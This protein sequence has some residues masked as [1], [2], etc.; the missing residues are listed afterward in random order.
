MVQFVHPGA[1]DITL[2]GVLAA[3]ADPVRLAIV[4]ALMQRGDCASCTGLTPSGQ[5][6]KSTLSRHF[7]ILRE[8]GL[9]HTAKKGVENSNGLRRA[10]IEAKFPGLL[11]LV[12][13]L[14]EPK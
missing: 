3:L 6:A 14:A 5:V 9:I 13:K 12:A 2:E 7:R 11:D 8:S 1:Q 4:K 10:D